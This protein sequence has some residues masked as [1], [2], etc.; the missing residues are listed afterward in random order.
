MLTRKAA[1]Y[2]KIMHY[3]RGHIN[4]W[5]VSIS[6]GHSCPQMWVIHVK[7]TSSVY[8]IRLRK[9][10]PHQFYS[11]SDLHIQLLSTALLPLTSWT[12]W[13]SKVCSLRPSVQDT[14]DHHF[15][16]TKLQTPTSSSIPWTMLTWQPYSI[17]T[18]QLA[19]YLALVHTSTY[20][21]VVKPVSEGLAPYVWWK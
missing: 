14:L 21:I 16:Y 6:C 1:D 15:R 10:H 8:I 18:F 17:V 9:F 2:N 12:I 7:L 13:S 20:L 11:T 3:A 19:R 5:E 4:F